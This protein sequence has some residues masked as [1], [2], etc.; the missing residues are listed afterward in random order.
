MRKE[1]RSKIGSRLC[2]I[3]CVSLVFLLTLFSFAVA[4]EEGGDTGKTNDAGSVIETKESPEKESGNPFVINSIE[5]QG[6][7][8]MPSETILGILQTRIGDEVSPD[9]L[10]LIR[11]DVKELYKLGQFSNIRVE[12]SGSEEGI[13]LTFIMEEWAKVSEI[14]LVGNEEISDGKIKNALTVAPGRSL[15]GK[16]LHDNKNKITSLYKKKGYYL[17]QVESNAVSD[18]Q[19]SVKLS[20]DINEGRKLEV[21]EID[22]IGNRR[23]SDREIKKQMK[24]KKGKRFDDAYFEGDLRNIN[25]YYHLNGFLNAKI[26]SSGKELNE[27]QSGLIVRVELMEGPQYRIGQVS[28]QI[29]SYGGSEPLFTEEEALKEFVLKEGDIFNEATFAESLWKIDKIYRDKGRVFV[30]IKPDRDYDPEAEIVNV[31]LAISEGGLAYID[32]TIINWVSETSDEPHK[33]KEYVVR[34]ELDRFD[35][36]AGELLSYQN[37]ADARRR[38][39]TLGPFIRGA[40]PQPLLSPDSDSEDGGQRVIVNFDIEESRQSGM[41]S[42]AGGYGSEGGVFG[43]LDIWDDNILGRA[44]RLHV[45]GEIGTRERRTGQVTFNTPWVFGTPTSLGFSLYSRRRS[46]TGGYYPDEDEQA[47]YK[48]ESVGGSATIGRPLTRQINLSIGLRNEN[49]SYK[50]L[51]GDVWEEMYRGKTRSVKFIVDRDTRQFLTSM[52]DPNR[53]SHNTFS[54]EY[55]G[56]GGDEFQKYM[57]ESSVFI[58]TWWKLVLVFHGRAGYLSGEYPKIYNLRYERFFL[59]GIDSIRGYNHFSITPPGYEI[60][61]GNQMAMLNVEY[62]FPITDML[63][64][65]VFFDV[66]QTWD[67]SKYPWDNFK[68]R[69]SVGIGLRVDLLG[70]LARLEYG[71]PLDGAGENDAVKNGQFQFDIGPAF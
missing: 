1:Q 39:L 49:V 3:F 30:Q 52:F 44:W 40:H 64:G 60:M 14:A 34:R 58:P 33:T 41:F 56:L 69:K 59:G 23:V 55:S 26:V 11:D 35:I 57:L 5:V 51:M 71:I 38:I 53:G 42:I 61:G 9:T 15:S 19:G 54:V 10:K 46:S 18:P 2:L 68:P 6:S 50:E 13:R 43:A 37:I 16:L 8:T 70:A 28:A 62:R 4:E 45:R 47:L 31:K 25:S 48:D 67:D 65:L 32:K 27:D 24:I 20:F 29:L 21:V 36:K 22:I 63:R 66:G 17:A 7:K 12:S